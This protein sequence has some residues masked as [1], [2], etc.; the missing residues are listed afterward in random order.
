MSSIPCWF[1]E[2]RRTV[3]EFPERDLPTLAQVITPVGA[4]LRSCAPNW[5][6]SRGKKIGVAAIL[7]V[8]QVLDGVGFVGR[9]E[10]EVIPIGCDFPELFD[11]LSGDNVGL[12]NPEFG[13]LAVGYEVKV[14][15]EHRPLL[16]LIDDCSDMSDPE[17]AGVKCFDDDTLG[18]GIVGC[19]HVSCFL[20]RL[21][22]RRKPGNLAGY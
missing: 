3:V 8:L 17:C 6:K 22:C 2:R 20:L 12:L 1:G 19:G 21:L 13:F 9:F 11:S 16:V 5:S 14:N 15:Q 4:D 10:R 18:G 7:A